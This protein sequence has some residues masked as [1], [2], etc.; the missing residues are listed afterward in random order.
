MYI[1]VHGFGIDYTLEGP[2]TDTTIIFIHG[3]PLSKEMWKP[4]M[5]EFKKEYSVLSYD[6]RGHGL[7][8]VGNGQYTIE[9][10]VDDLFGLMDILHI[11]KAVLVGLSMGGYIAL[12]AVEK[13]EDRF[14]GLV[15]CDT[16]SEDDTNE[17][18]IKRAHQAKSVKIYGM[19]KFANLFLPTALTQNN[20]KKRTDVFRRMHDIIERNSSN[21]MAGIMIAL[22]AR[23]NTTPFLPSIKIPTLI[24]VGQFDEI[25][26]PSVSIQMKEKITDSEMHIIPDAAHLSNTEN[27]DE[28]NKYL[29]K[30]LK[31]LD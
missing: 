2:K 26:P 19:N 21:A 16:R 18:K 5:E 25:T 3:F 17:I 12:R 6:V 23:T 15:L 31:S 22:A 1:K 11:Q 20:V 10:C 14:K 8:D 4:Q 9:Y 28:F 29:H 24:M 7:S 27:P 30:F 13:H